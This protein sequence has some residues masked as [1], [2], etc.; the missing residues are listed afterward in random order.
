MERV[1]QEDLGH[2]VRRINKATGSPA[3]AYTKTNDKYTANI[4]NYHLDYAYG[5]VQLIR[6]VN[7]GGGVENIST[8]GFGTKRQLYHWMQA[9]L[10]GVDKSYCKS[11]HEEIE[12]RILTMK[13]NSRYNHKTS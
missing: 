1:K 10:V 3:V 5:G 6:M 11:C 4:G 9:F 12:Q 13:K 8:Q 2:L 7:D